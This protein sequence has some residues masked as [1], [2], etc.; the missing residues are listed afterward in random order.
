MILAENVE[1]MLWKVLDL[2]NAGVQLR[3]LALCVV[4]RKSHGKIACMPRDCRYA[5]S[6]P[7]GTTLIYVQCS[8]RYKIQLQY[9]GVVMAARHLPVRY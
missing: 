7:Y 6:Y 4:V 8:A 2:T 5:K 3:C 1:C 9:D